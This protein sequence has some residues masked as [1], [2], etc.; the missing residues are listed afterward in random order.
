MNR[1]LQNMIEDLEIEAREAIDEVK[2][3]HRARFEA[4]IECIDR[5]CAA[6]LQPLEREYAAIARIMTAALCSKGC[7]LLIA[8]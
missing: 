5:Y 4:I 1:F 3:A 2:P 7:G 8:A 6:H